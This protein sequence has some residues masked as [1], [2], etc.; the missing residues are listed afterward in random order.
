MQDLTQKGAVREHV[1][2][3]AFFPLLEHQ[4]LPELLLVQRG[5]PT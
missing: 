2:A 4:L 3:V 5:P 1:A